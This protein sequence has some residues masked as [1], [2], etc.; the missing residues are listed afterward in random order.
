MASSL[1]MMRLLIDT[2]T[3]SF[4]L[5][6]DGVAKLNKGDKLVWTLIDGIVE[7]NSRVLGDRDEMSQLTL[8]SIEFKS[9]LAVAALA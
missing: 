2:T 4:I 1:E 5:I 9:K 6:W 8:V 3:V 7:E